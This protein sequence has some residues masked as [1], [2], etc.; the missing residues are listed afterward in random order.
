MAEWTKAQVC[1][2]CT[3]VGSNPT[4]RSVST[5]APELVVAPSIS[6][7]DIVHRTCCVDDNTAICG[8]SLPGIEWTD[9][10]VTCIMCIRVEET[11]E[12]PVRGTC[13]YPHLECDDRT[14]D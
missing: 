2:T 6:R 12:C 14:P 10:P 11:D 13:H 5:A 1:S 4:G 7:V 9:D 8:V 3:V